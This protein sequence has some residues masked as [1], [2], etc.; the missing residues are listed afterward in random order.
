M[1]KNTIRK[2]KNILLGT[3]YFWF[4]ILGSFLAESI[5]RIIFQEF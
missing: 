1:K 5:I 2:I 4:P 3:S